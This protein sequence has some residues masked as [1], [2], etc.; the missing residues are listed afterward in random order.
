[1]PL[2]TAIYLDSEIESL[3]ALKHSQIDII[4]N[5]TFQ[6]WGAWLNEV[7][8]KTIYAPKY[9]LGHKINKEYPKQVIPDGWRQI[10]V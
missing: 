1:M 7:P 10:K 6:W 5:S 8:N 4:S 2:K 3:L 9:W